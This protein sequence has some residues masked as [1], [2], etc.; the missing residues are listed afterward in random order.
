QL[1]GPT[2][3]YTHRLREPGVAAGEAPAA[4]PLREPRDEGRPRATARLGDEGRSE[5]AGDIGKGRPGAD[6]T[7]TPMEFPLDRDGRLQ[8]LARGDEGFLLAL[9]Y[10]TQRGYARTHPFVGE[11]RIGEV[12]LEL[13][14]PEL[15]FPAPLGRIRLTE[16]QMVNQ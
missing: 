3:D 13:D 14:V 9:A 2:F 12:E 5:P 8:A 7:R 11:V 6:I 1:L 4:A 10:S 15:P 16:C